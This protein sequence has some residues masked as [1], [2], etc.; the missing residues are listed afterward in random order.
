MA[1]AND[2]LEAQRQIELGRIP[3]WHGDATKDAFTAE[4]WIER[5]ENC[6]ATAHWDDQAT[7]GYM[8]QALRGR[9]I[10]W[11]TNAKFRRVD[12]AVWNSTRDDF[13][14]VYAPAKTVRSTIANLEAKQHATESVCDYAS[15]V[16]LIVTDLYSIIEP[17][18]D[19][20]AAVLFGPDISVV[21]AV[22]ALPLADR[23]AQHNRIR[24]IGEDRVVQLIAVNLFVAGL[25][26]HIRQKMVTR[27]YA[28]FAD[29]FDAAM[30][31]EVQLSEPKRHATVLMVD[32]EKNVDQGG[33]DEESD[34][35]DDDEEDIVAEINK[36]SARLAKTRV[37]KNKNKTKSGYS[38]GGG[39]R[40]KFTCRYCKQAG[41]MQYTCIKRKNDRAPMVGPDGKPYRRRVQELTQVSPSSNQNF[42]K[43]NPPPYQPS[44]EVAGIWQSPLNWY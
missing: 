36:L 3:L 14:K 31:F 21:A 6:R 41:H 22:V 12:T 10:H 29:A 18:A 23:V 19:P 16:T 8:F 38:G 1:A 9:A 34:D 42:A 13:L 27:R 26:P 32:A 4:Q 40:G 30:N 33:D 24:L 7:I 17:Y 39:E 28:T 35:H 20:A 37:N 2:L 43:D 44:Q 11:F 25:K 15:R 5:I